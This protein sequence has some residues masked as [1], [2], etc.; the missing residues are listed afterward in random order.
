LSPGDIATPMSFYTSHECNAPLSRPVQRTGLSPSVHSGD[1]PDKNSPAFA[2]ARPLAR[3]PATFPS[4]VTRGVT[5]C[6]KV[7]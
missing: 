3:W 6:L 4:V 2:L 7:S 5:R 1:R